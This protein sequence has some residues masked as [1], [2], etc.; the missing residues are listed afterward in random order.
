MSRDAELKDLFLERYELIVSFAGR[1]ARKTQEADDIV[2]QVYLEFVRHPDRWDTSTDV[3]PL[4]VGIT[5]N[6]AKT[7]M[8]EE[9]RHSAS[10]IRRIADRYLE[11]LDA[12]EAPG[13]ETPL[14]EQMA[15][16][17]TCLDQLKPKSRELI[18]LRYW[19]RIPVKMIGI[20]YRVDPRNVSKALCKI[21]S[22]LK[23][24]ITSARNR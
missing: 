18:E 4:L 15:L 2:Q 10:R 7:K 1:Y 14:A 8:R 5:K 21:R 12:L 16:L 6:I 9:Y 20:I 23:K 13:E 17:E 19:K 3:T 11:H 24:C 22:V